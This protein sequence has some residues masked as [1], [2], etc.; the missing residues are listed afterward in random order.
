MAPLIVLG[1]WHGLDKL[2]AADQHPQRRALAN[3]VAGVLLGS[4]IACNG[5]ILGV[6]AVVARSSDF[7]TRCQAGEHAEL[8]AVAKALRTRQHGAL[9]VAARYEDPNRQGQS[10]FGPRMVKLLTG[11]EVLIPPRKLRDREELLAWARAAQVRYL[12]T[13]P[14]G[15][16]ATR[17]WHFRLGKSEGLPFYELLE[18]T[19]DGAKAVMLPSVTEGVR[20]VPGL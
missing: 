10:D 16:K 8:I 17:A 20:R 11:K 3:A 9:A 6:A 4:V 5:L 1:I 14:P 19:D 7:V 2:L 12:L 18:L 15:K 13:R